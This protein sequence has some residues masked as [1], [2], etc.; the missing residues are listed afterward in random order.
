MGLHRTRRVQ[1]TVGL[2]IAYVV[3][4]VLAVLFLF[5]FLWMVSSSLKTPQEL[6]RI[7]P[8]LVPET[9]AW[10]NYIEAWM[11]QPFLSYFRN[12]TLITALNVIGRVI[13][14]SLVAF[15]FARTKFPGRNF[16]FVLLLSTMMLPTQ[17][18]LIPQ[19]LLFRQLNW[20]N[21]IK[22][23]TVPA[24]FGNAF[25]IFL[26]RQFFMTALELD[27]AAYRWGQP[28]EHLPAYRHAPESFVLLTVLIFTFINT[29]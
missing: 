6:V 25:H 18:T 27:E 28:L 8:T 2:T 21:T 3:T 14:C 16:L 26:L 7:P 11:S 15:G 9:W 10:G 4:T 24:F 13:S 20:I 19:Y 23:L 5:P 1:R 22:P 17:V 12:S 29:E